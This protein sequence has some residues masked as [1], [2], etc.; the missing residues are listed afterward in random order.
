M[1]K[2]RSGSAFGLSAIPAN[3]VA[4]MIAGLFLPLAAIAAMVA[5]VRLLTGRFPFLSHV[6][7][8][9]GGE[10][11]LTLELVPPEQVRGLWAEHKR[12]FGEPLQELQLEIQA[13]AEQAKPRSGRPS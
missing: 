10:R 7:P 4:G 6:V 2:H 13:M 5:G 8:A 9:E 11:Q 1:A 3:L 12:T